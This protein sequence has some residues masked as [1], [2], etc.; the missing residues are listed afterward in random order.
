MKLLKFKYIQ[1]L[2][3]VKF[4]IKFGQTQTKLIEI[5]NLFMRSI[6]FF[7]KITNF[8]LIKFYVYYLII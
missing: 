4:N 8:V 1:V 3:K 5:K 6:K 7:Y 2:I